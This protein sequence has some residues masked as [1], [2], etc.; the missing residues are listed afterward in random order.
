MKK[1]EVAI[2]ILDESYVDSLIVALARQGYAPYYNAE[3]KPA[4]VCFSASEDEVHELTGSAA[5]DSRIQG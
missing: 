1:Y 5:K 4:V 2:S 3:D